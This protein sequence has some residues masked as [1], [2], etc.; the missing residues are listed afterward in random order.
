[1]SLSWILEE[2]KLLKIQQNHPREHMD[3]INCH[4]LYINSESS[5][6]NIA[7]ESVALEWNAD[8]TMK[9]IPKERVLRL[10]QER[11]KRPSST[12]YIYNDACLYLV[13]LEPE[14]IQNYSDKSFLTNLRA[15]DDICVGPS[16]FVF[17]SI[18]AVYFIFQE[19]KSIL[20]KGNGKSN[21][22]KMVSIS[23]NN[24]TRK[25]LNAA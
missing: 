2:E 11:R 1:M 25:N 15:V 24:K 7:T 22:K 3:S 6:D 9:I 14:H 16:I 21:T 12:Q 20:K 18:N 17:H 23:V 8:K 19:I 10:I 4:F 5:I 13:D